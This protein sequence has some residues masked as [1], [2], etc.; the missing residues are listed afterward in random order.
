M[1]FCYSSF[2]PF[3]L[4]ETKTLTLCEMIF[5]R[6]LKGGGKCVL[7][8]HTHTIKYKLLKHCGRTKWLLCDK[9]ILVHY[10]T[11]YAVKWNDTKILYAWWREW[12]NKEETLRVCCTAIDLFIIRAENL[13]VG[14]MENGNICHIWEKDN[15]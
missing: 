2:F 10:V 6:E 15:G 13:Y 1:F 11:F 5:N 7:Y 8:T 9:T 12:G 14:V 3:P 4:S